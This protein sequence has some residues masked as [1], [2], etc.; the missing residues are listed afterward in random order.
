MYPRERVVRRLRLRK[1]DNLLVVEQGSTILGVSADGA[2][3]IWLNILAT[4][5]PPKYEN[6]QY[7]C[8]PHY[9]N[10]LETRKGSLIYIGSVYSDS[11]HLFIFEV[12]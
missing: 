4:V 9:D 7:I 12:E 11:E 2:T 6:R 8:V 10:M 5:T 1:G 3:G